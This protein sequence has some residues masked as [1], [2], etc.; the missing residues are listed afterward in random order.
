MPQ[1]LSSPALPGRE[2]PGRH[3]WWAAEV[4]GAVT[5]KCP[6]TSVLSS[7]EPGGQKAL[8]WVEVELSAYSRCSGV[9]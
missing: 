7:K 8:W 2:R 1:T 9:S 4:K 6:S 3:Q 5:S